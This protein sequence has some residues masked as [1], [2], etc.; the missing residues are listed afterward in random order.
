[1]RERLFCDIQSGED[2]RGRAI[3]DI[4]DGYPAVLAGIGPQSSNIGSGHISV[5]LQE[6]GHKT[7]IAEN[8]G[9]R[10]T[11]RRCLQGREYC[12]C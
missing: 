6:G 12:S 7:F 5:N 4:E 1:M 11:N 10:K 8:S 9:I 3:H 2:I